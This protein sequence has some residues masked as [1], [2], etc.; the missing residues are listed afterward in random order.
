MKYSNIKS[1]FIKKQ[2][3]KTKWDNR[4]YIDD[5]VKLHEYMTMELNLGLP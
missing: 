5:L 3:K 1:P 2:L 4:S